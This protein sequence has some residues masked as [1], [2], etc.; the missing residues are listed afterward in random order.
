MWEHGGLSIWHNGIRTSSTSLFQDISPFVRIIREHFSLEPSMGIL[1]I[2]LSLPTMRNAWHF[3]GKGKMKWTRSVEADGRSSRT[4]N[5][6]GEFIFMKGMAQGS[7]RKKRG[8]Q[9]GAAG[10]T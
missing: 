7:L 8:E 1:T 9:T 10:E 4:D 5:S 3:P 2:V 6:R